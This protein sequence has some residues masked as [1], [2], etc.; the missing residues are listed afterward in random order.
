MGSNTLPATKATTK[1]SP[2][3]L[4]L[5]LAAATLMVFVTL[6]VGIARREGIGLTRMPPAQVV[7]SVTLRV[8]DRP[9]GAIAISDAALNRLIATVQPGQDN[10]L[11]ATLRGFAQARLRAGLDREPPFR[12]THFDDGSLQLDDPVTGRAVNLGA[13]GPSNF[14]AFARLLPDTG[15]Q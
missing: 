6:S 5:G 13:F 4:H 7:R 9:D 8:E 11:R 1:T 12:L 2:I 10:F 14:S 15:V 3:P